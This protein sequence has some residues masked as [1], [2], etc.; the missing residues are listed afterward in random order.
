M[1]TPSSTA[2]QESQ[3]VTP[4]HMLNATSM[5]INQESQVVTPIF[6]VNTLTP[7]VYYGNANTLPVYSDSSELSR[8]SVYQT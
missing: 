3:E 4:S 2:S 5:P 8:H 6:P 7:T 1:V